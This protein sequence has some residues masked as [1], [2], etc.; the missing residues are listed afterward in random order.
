MLSPEVA[1]CSLSERV[2]AN[3]AGDTKDGIEAS[4][5]GHTQSGAETGR[6]GGEM[7]EAK[8]SQKTEKG[9]LVLELI[10]LDK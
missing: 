9:F 2:G 10:C 5:I 6:G 4:Y 8:C 7:E 1:L 3:D